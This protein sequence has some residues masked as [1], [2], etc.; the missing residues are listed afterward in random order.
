MDINSKLTN[1]E[2]ITKILNKEIKLRH[3]SILGEKRA[4]EIRLKFLEKKLNSEFTN[5]NLSILNPEKCKPNIE[6]MVGST[7]IPLG[8]AGPIL[9]NFENKSKE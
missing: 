4:T 9:I 2:I 6:N 8:I 7:Q 5:I 3:L 1:E